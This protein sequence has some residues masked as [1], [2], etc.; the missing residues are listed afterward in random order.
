[1]QTIEVVINHRFSEE[2]L[3]ELRGVSSRLHLRQ[4]RLRTADDY[5]SLDLSGVQ[6][7]Y[8]GGRLRRT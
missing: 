5:R 1:M 8:A 4:E 3:D 7:L 2:T 6:I